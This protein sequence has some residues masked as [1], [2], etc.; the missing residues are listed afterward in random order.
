MKYKLRLS[1][2][3][4]VI[5]QEFNMNLLVNRESSYVINKSWKTMSVITGGLIF[6]DSNYFIKDMSDMDVNELY[7]Y[8]E[9]FSKLCIKCFT[10]DPLHYFSGFALRFDILLKVTGVKLDIISDIGVYESIKNNILWEINLSG[11][12]IH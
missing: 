10:I 11:T 7:H 3:I 12:I 8:L 4:Y 1:K 2:N 9:L 6:I 5:L